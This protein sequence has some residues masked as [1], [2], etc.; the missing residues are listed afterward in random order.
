M[1]K[2]VIELK[3]ERQQFDDLCGYFLPLMMD[4]CD[5]RVLMYEDTDQEFAHRVCRSVMEGVERMFM[6]KQLSDSR[7]IKLK[8]TE[9]EALITMQ[10][11][12]NFPLPEDHIW[13]HNLRNH[14]IHTID[15]QV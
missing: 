7:K 4:F 3:L 5:S 11:L 13:R 14:I 6:K 15:K 10:L 8:L 9:A 1:K 2:P 12:V